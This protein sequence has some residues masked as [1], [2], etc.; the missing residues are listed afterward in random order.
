[1][2][3][4]E[5]DGIRKLSHEDIINEQPTREIKV[6]SKQ[7]IVYKLANTQVLQK[8]CKKRKTK[9][10]WRMQNVNV[11]NSTSIK[12]SLWSKKDI[13]SN[14]FLNP[15]A[16]TM[17][18]K[19]NTD[20]CDALTLR[21]QSIGL[22]SMHWTRRETD[23]LLALC[24]NFGNRWGVIID[25]YNAC[26]PATRPTRDITQIKQRYYECK[27]LIESFMSSTP[28]T[29]F[30]YDAKAEQHRRNE[31]SKLL[32][33][34]HDENIEIAQTAEYYRKHNKLL[35]KKVNEMH[36]KKVQLMKQSTLIRQRQQMTAQRTQEMKEMKDSPFNRYAGYGVIIQDTWQGNH[37][38]AHACDAHTYPPCCVPKKVMKMKRYIQMIDDEYTKYKYELKLD[39]QKTTVIP[40]PFID[41]AN[42]TQQNIKKN[43]GKMDTDVNGNGNARK[44]QEQLLVSSNPNVGK[45]I[46]KIVQQELV[47]HDVISIDPFGNPKVHPMTN[48][49]RNMVNV[50]REDYIKYYAMQTLINDLKKKQK[51]K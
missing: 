40:F 34:S 32:M 14:S 5:H 30:E 35:R 11:S 15:S 28:I 37:K 6:C 13:H 18:Y 3:A 1:M 24:N 51:K 47:N 48:V 23:L 21:Y 16:P 43:K 8:R 22:S 39:G 19:Q 46:A 10:Q 2:L 50:L 17:D 27:N 44:T 4:C 36:R 42:K 33:R 38:E 25:R 29:P 45:D 31:L 26:K 12:V 9:R 7:K 20:D 41:K 49:T